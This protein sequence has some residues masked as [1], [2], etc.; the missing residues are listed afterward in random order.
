MKNTVFIHTN[1]KQI[2]GAMLAKHATESR[3]TVP[4]SVDVRYINVDELPLFQNFIGTEYLFTPT[5]S[6]TY[7]KDDLQSFTLSRFMPP[8]LMGYEGKAVVIDPDIFALCD[9]NEL[10]NIDMNGA[11][12]AACKKKDAWDTSV[13][14]LDCAKL[15]HWNIATI[16]ES[17]RAHTTNYMDI[18]TLQSET[19]SIQEL[20]RIW[21]HLDE[22]TPE[23]KIIHMTR[24]LTQPWKTGLPVDFTRNK[25]KKFFGIIP[26]EP[27]Y[28]LLGKLDTVYQQHPNKAIEQ[29]FFDLTKNAVRDGAITPLDVQK[30][31]ELK[32][33][34]S[35]LLEKLA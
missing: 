12:I 21:N 15:K 4:D 8:E 34:R 6:R 29:L 16:L 24:R 30:E 13:M 10:F 9:V 14:L 22:Y 31:I 7:T 2:L 25:L 11:A 19:V 5:E 17:L 1:N 20:P 26:R 18:M 27:I 23:T 28:A 32:H 33:V 3:L 35:D